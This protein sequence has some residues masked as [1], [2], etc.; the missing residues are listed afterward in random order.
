VQEADSRHNMVE[1]LLS[2]AGFVR[3]LLQAKAQLEA[4]GDIENPLS[5]KV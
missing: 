4:I 2:D 3:L 1:A 5:H